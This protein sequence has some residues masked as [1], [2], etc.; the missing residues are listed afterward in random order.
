VDGVRAQAPLPFTSW[1]RRR[2]FP[3]DPGEADAGSEKLAY[4]FVENG[5]ASW[6]GDHDG[7]GSGPEGGVGGSGGDGEGSATTWRVWFR[8]P[9]MEAGERAVRV[10]PQS[11]LFATLPAAAPAK[12]SRFSSSSYYWQTE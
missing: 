5:S 1:P 9:P 12:S 11:P 10:L 4:F 7:G 2:I 3:T 6:R 8:L